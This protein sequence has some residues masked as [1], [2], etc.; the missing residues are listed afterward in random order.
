MTSCNP[1]IIAFSSI[2]HERN[3][4]IYYRYF[5]ES[6]I[7]NDSQLEEKT[8]NR[9]SAGDRTTVLCI[10]F[11]YMNLYNQSVRDLYEK[12]YRFGYGL[13]CCSVE[14]SPAMDRMTSQLLGWQVF[15]LCW[16]PNPGLLRGVA[17]AQPPQ[18]TPICWNICMYAEKL[19]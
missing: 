16:D 18:R 2:R 5:D 6:G 4:F 15:L 1:L 19:P 17:I 14:E 7:R 3:W 10:K 8:A 11:Q 12:I 9:K 13:R